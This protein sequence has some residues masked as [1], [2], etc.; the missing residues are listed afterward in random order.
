MEPAETTTDK[1]MLLRYAGTC[2]LCGVELPARQQAI[3][4]RA[5]KS[6]RCVEC[7]AVAVK[8]EASPCPQS[9]RS[10]RPPRV[11]WPAPRPSENTSA[12]R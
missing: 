1:R 4:E 9:N 10:R 7:P 12:A 5:C 6:V 8:P 3:Y 11:E 2:R